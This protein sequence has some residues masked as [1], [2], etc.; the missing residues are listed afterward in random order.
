M[1]PLIRAQPLPGVSQFQ[2]LHRFNRRT[3][4]SCDSPAS[5]CLSVRKHT[6]GHIG[7]GIVRRSGLTDAVAEAWAALRIPTRQAKT[8]TRSSCWLAPP[9][10]NIS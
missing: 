1:H 9:T 7:K 8:I 10:P 6:L 2:L 4:S 3:R 5:A